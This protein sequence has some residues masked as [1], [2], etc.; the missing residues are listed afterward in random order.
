MAE[1]EFKFIYKSE[2]GASSLDAY[3]ASQ[4]LYG[5]SR[6]IAIL[7]HYTIHRRVIK[8]A[9]ALEGAKVLIEPPHHGSFEF[10][11]PIIADPDVRAVAQNISAAMLYDLVKVIYRRLVGKSDTPSSAE[12]QNLVRR[13]PGDL[14]A[15]SDSI[16]EDMVR[17]Y[18]PLISDARQYNIT[19]NG[20]TVNIVNVVELNRETYDFA[21]TKVLGDDQVE[22]FG[23]VRSF[24]GSTIQGRFWIEEEERT[25]G[26]S[27]NK[28]TR[29]SDAAR[30]TL[31]WSSDEWVNE[32]EGYVFL[33]GY[34]LSSRTGLLKHIF[35]TGVRRA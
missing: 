9:P 3:D 4:A 7:T 28:T 34:P 27:K 2:D 23:E 19:V 8:Q 35:M 1:A 31:S 33:R 29:M 6:S 18:R 22:F 30:Q 12:V 25:V 5:I 32:R 21:K 15:L 10:I 16:N 26:F 24:N 17:I 13:A 20:G 11:V 14:D